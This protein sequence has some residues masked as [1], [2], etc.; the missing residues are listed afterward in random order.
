[1]GALS[2]AAFIVLLV[3]VVI[4]GGDA[5]FYLQGGGHGR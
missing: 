3:C 5:W 1:V 4:V 2:M